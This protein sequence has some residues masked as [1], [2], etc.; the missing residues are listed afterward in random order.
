MFKTILFAAAA[1]SALLATPSIA[2]PT[3]APEGARIEASTAPIAS[4]AKR[5]TRYCVIDTIIGSHIPR[6]EC[7]T[8]K[9]WIELTGTDP[10]A[11]N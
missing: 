11:K 9:D 1:S 6:K 4:T 8:R 2:A 10:L 5:E 7:H 3:G